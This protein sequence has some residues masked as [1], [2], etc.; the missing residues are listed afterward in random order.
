MVPVA[1]HD[2]NICTDEVTP[3]PPPSKRGRAKVLQTEKEH[4]KPAD[5]TTTS[6]AGSE[7]TTRL[8]CTEAKSSKFWQITVE[9][10]KTITVYGKIG[11]T[12]VT[13]E[14]SHKDA[15][16]A[17][18]F[19][20]KEIAS[21]QKKGYVID[22]SE[23]AVDSVS[24]SNVNAG[25]TSCSAQCSKCNTKAAQ[26]TSSSWNGT[27]YFC[28]AISTVDEES[29]GLDRRS[30][31]I[32]FT[33]YDDDCEQDDDERLCLD[34]LKEFE[35]ENG[36]VGTT[37]CISV[38][39]RLNAEKKL[40]KIPQVK[41][42]K[43]LPKVIDYDYS[44]VEDGQVRPQSEACL[45]CAEDGNYQVISAESGCWKPYVSIDNPTDVWY[46]YHIDHFNDE[47]AMCW[48]CFKNKA[49]IDEAEVLKLYNANRHILAP[50][51]EPCV[52]EE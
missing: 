30:V 14:K 28:S 41:A 39:E 34:C 36:A 8:T 43:K 4:D 38:E 11:S 31:L 16:S 22:I 1:E 7:T 27:A 40:S 46:L 44:K 29:G 19:A 13:G 32:Y 47:G 6:S 37:S 21:K 5:V 3:I 20:T 18:S 10:D 2:P 52:E 35:Q 25:S 15:E 50:L 17:K 23:K 49:E 26:Y 48:S 42:F 12:G 33:K 51:R 9:G 45:E 24:S